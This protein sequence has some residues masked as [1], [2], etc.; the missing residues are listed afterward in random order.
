MI[1][2]PQALQQLLASAVVLPGEA[3]PLDQANG[4]VLAADVISERA[5]PAFDNAAMDGFA[6]AAHGQEISA[7][8]T[9]AV[10][11]W[12]AAG[13]P[14]SAAGQGTWEIMTGARL[15]DGLDTVVP[16]E[17]VQVLEASNGRPLRI[18]L[19]QAIKPGQHV[20]LRGQD[21]AAGET[22][23]SAGRTLDLNA[24]TLLQALG[25][26]SVQVRQRP[27][28]AVIS[29]GKE[30]VDDTRQALGSGQIRDSNRPYLLGRMQAA[31]AEV[32]HQDMVGDDNAAFERAVDA[33]LAAGARVL[34][35]TGAVSQGRYDFIPAALR[36][37]GAQ[38][39]FHKVAIRP[40]KPLLFARLA[41]GAL[42]FGLPGNPVSAAVGQRFFV[43]PLLRRQLG[44]ADEQPLWLP[45]HSEMRKPAGLRM[46]A[47]GR[48]LLDARGQLSAQVLPGQES[49]RLKTTV[50]ANAWLVADD[51]RDQLAAGER[52]QVYGWGHRDPL[53]LITQESA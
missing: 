3:V 49:F 32:V 35:S 14:A 50:Q 43:E 17:Q 10:D 28:V 37:R 18:R 48:I 47:R 8:S 11:G 16:V 9:W 51:Q 27:A 19:G 6:L 2:Y 36:A 30:L 25:I 15:P 42:F 52:V 29:T 40:G 12:Q 20:R 7:G 5:L 44:M 34:V 21:V 38:V 22:V 13:D 4:R 39:L 53:Q 1:S 45:L 24:M 41:G 31:G 23:L 33:A 26:A 46:H